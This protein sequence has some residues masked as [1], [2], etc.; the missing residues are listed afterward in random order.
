MDAQNPMIGPGSS[1]LL[2]DFLEL[3]PEWIKAGRRFSHIVM[4]PPYARVAPASAA[5][6]LLKSQGVNAHNLFAAFIWLAT[7]L[8]IEGG[9]L[10]AIVPRSF[11]SGLLYAPTRA[12][13]FANAGLYALHH[14]T[15]RR[16]V[17]ARDSVQ[18]EVVIFG[19]VRG[20]APDLVQFSQS[21]ALVVAPQS[22][23]LPKE[24]LV[25][26]ESER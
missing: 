7:D 25:L 4:N 9:R 22:V 1:V 6:L 26:P 24:R 19:V 8:L 17:F 14:F 18:Q 20:S 3:A 15:D 5:A 23:M 12:H 10:V 16:A 11:L 21:S 2:R 13:L